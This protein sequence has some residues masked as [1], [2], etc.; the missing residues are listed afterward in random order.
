MIARKKILIKIPNVNFGKDR[1]KATVQRYPPV[2][3]LT[4]MGNM[5]ERNKIFDIIMS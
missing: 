3:L 2:T 4:R 1:E 5:V